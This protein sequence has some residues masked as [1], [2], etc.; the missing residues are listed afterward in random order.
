MSSATGTDIYFDLPAEIID[1]TKWRVG[2]LFPFNVSLPYVGGGSGGSG[3]VTATFVGQKVRVQ[4][5][6]F[7]T[8]RLAGVDDEFAWVST[9]ITIV[10]AYVD[11]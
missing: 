7:A 3:E 11:E 9:N 1:T 4:V 6:K 8:N 10:L 2:L 5:P